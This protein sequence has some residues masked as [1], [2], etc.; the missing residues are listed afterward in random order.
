MGPDLSYTVYINPYHE[1]LPMAFLISIRKG[2]L[3]PLQ[4]LR[5]P[6][7]LDLI[8]SS[9]DIHIIVHEQPHLLTVI[10]PLVETDPSPEMMDVFD[11][12]SNYLLL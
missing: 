5:G 8:E 3:I 2:I 6:R 10:H 1:L 9:L 7:R 11:P 12:T 4:Q